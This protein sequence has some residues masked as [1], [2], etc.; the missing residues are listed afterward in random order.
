MQIFRYAEQGSIRF[1]WISGT[2]PAVSLPELRRIRSILAQDRLF[3]VVQDLFLTETAQLADV[4]LPAATWGEKTGTF[5]NADRTVHLSEKAVDPPGEARPDLDIFL[6]YAGRLAFR[7]RTAQPLVKWHDPEEAFEAW[8]E[9]SAGR[10]C[11]YTGLTYD[12]LRGGSGIQWPCNAEHPDGTERLYA[13]GTFW[14]DPDYCESYGRDLVTGAPQEPQ[15]YRAMNPDGKAC[16]RPPSTCRRTSSRATTTRSMLITG[17]TL[18]HFHTRTK[19]GRAPQLQQAAPEVWVEMSEHDTRSTGW[20]EGDLVEIS[21]PRGPGRG[22]AADQR[23]PARRGVPAVPLRLLGHPLGYEPELANG[24]AANELTI[25][26]WDPVSKQPLFKT[27]AAKVER[28]RLTDGEPSAAPTTTGSAPVR[29]IGVRPVVVSRPPPPRTSS[30]ARREV[31]DEEQGAAGAGGAP[32]LR[33]RSRRRAAACLGPAQGGPR[34]LLPGPGPGALVAAPCPRA[35][36]HRQGYGV[37]L[38]PEPEDESR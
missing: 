24:R 7:T 35:R 15:E 10:P 38:D 18:Y 4:V 14:A 2:N 5:T 21:T 36:P 29:G 33:E 13:D 27:A 12:K 22:A 30:A 8:K 17:R 25:T 1:L 19:T 28:I 32:S 16:S 11:D 6:D 3:L 26:D 23:H 9:C 20:T 34:D 37:E 31:P